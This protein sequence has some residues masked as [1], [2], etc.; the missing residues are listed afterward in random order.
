MTLSLKV[1]DANFTKFFDYAHIPYV[2]SALAL[3]F[4]GTDV[5]SSQINRVEGA[6]APLATVLG[7]P[8]YS[9][10]YASL[11][12][13]NGFDSTIVGGN[14]SFTQV[15]VHGSFGA[16]LGGCGHTDG[17]VHKTLLYGNALNQ[18]YANQDTAV[19]ASG[20]AFPSTVNRHQVSA[21][22]YNGTDSRLDRIVAGARTTVT[23][24]RAPGAT[25]T[26]SWRIGGSGVGGASLVQV[27][28]AALFSRELTG[29]ELL[30]VYAFM[31]M[32]VEARGV[33]IA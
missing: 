5:G 16:T 27:S 20:S 14:A 28:A 15:L 31:K 26:K 22:T 21:Y 23:A 19:A 25:A 7:A 8:T 2:E 29:A 9:T 18:L 32:K 17:S 1:S 13:A 24:A 4:L 3:F 33:L 6:S 10:G 11:S 30:N 12:G